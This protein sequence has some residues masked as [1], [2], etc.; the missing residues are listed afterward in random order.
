MKHP[1]TKLTIKKHIAAELHTVFGAI[2]VF[3]LL[4]S[5]GGNAKSRNLSPTN[6]ASSSSQIQPNNHGPDLHIANE[7]KNLLEFIG[8]WGVCGY[9]CLLQVLREKAEN[10]SKTKKRKSD[11][12]E[13]YSL[14]D[15]KK[16]DNHLKSFLYEEFGGQKSRFSFKNST[17]TM[18]LKEGKNAT[19][20]VKELANKLLT[21]KTV[22]GKIQPRFFV[23][24]KFI[25]FSEK[26]QAILNSNVDAKLMADQLKQAFN[27]LKSE[28]NRVNKGT[29]EGIYLFIPVDK[30]ACHCQDVDNGEHVVGLC[31]EKAAKKSKKHCLKKTATTITA[32]IIS[33]I[34]GEISK[35][36]QSVND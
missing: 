22:P 12:V 3:F 6:S 10:E 4:I 15:E 25:E 18:T 2:L 11:G 28:V 9:T 21:D 35:F 19:G 34:G 32:D 31:F 23:V 8:S 1:K 17:A 29:G 20:K 13:V 16:G 33:E 30:T 27:K 7:K 26:A 5:C 24:T 36:S 14:L